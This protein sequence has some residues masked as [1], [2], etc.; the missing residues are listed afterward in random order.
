MR[1]SANLARAALPYAVVAAL[2]GAALVPQPVTP[3]ITMAT[4]LVLGGLLAIAGGLTSSRTHPVTTGMLVSFGLACSVWFAVTASTAVNPQVAWMGIIAQH[5]G[6]ATWLMG[7][8]WML[9]ALLLADRKSLKAVLLA[10]TVAGVVYAAAAF[11][12]FV[13]G[14]IARTGDHS[15]GFFEN[16]VSFG[17]FLALS[18]ICAGAWTLTQRDRRTKVAGAVVTVALIAML[19]LS[20]SRTA[21]IALGVAAI[22]WLLLS[23]LAPKTAAGARTYT[24]GLTAAPLGLSVLGIAAAL[25]A[26]GTS[27]ASLVQRFSSGRDDIWAAAWSR[28]SDSPVTGHGLEHFST[29]TSWTLT[30]EAISSKATTDAHSIALSLGLGGG[31]VG[32]ALVSCTLWFLNAAMVDAARTARSTPVSLLA[33]LPLALAAAGSVGWIA[34]ASMLVG[35]VAIGA[36]SGATT[37]ASASPKAGWSTRIVRWTAVGIG[38]LAVVLGLVGL[39]NVG[40][41][42][43]HTGQQDPVVLTEIHRAWPDPAFATAALQ[44]LTPRIIQGDAAAAQLARDVITASSDDAAWRVELTGAQLIASQALEASDASRFPEFER[45]VAQGVLADPASGL[46]YTFAAYEADRLELSEKAR[47]YA[48]RALE[49]EVS[50]QTRVELEALLAR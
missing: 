13:S 27:A 29:W 20:D 8:A 18:I 33:T 6:T 2:L 23:R 42:L 49:F 30:S 41:E 19:D 47:E 12:E 26:F 36:V 22:A 31:L 10:T 11:Y 46:W 28:L 48:K 43:K 21:L 50:E 45:V 14:G 34:P 44:L 40:L 39:R 37:E 35:A 9:A 4:G 38:S 3:G 15:R 32:L 24:I 17:Q 5:N 16:S 7:F 1:R 25:G